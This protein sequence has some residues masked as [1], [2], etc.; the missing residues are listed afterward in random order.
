MLGGGGLMQKKKK[1]TPAAS[2]AG[3][4]PPYVWVAE[5]LGPTW[6]RHR[7]LMVKKNE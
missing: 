2:A 7:M 3:I 6:H 4:F 1:A 5:V